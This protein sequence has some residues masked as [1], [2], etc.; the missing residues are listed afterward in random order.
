MEAAYTQ[1]GSGLLASFGNLFNLRRTDRRIFVAAG[2]AA[3]ISAAFNAPLAGAFYAYELTLGSYSQ[4]ALA[5][6]ATPC[7]TR[8]I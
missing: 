3:A 8:I 2:A 4:G 5:R 1:M 7:R 6:R